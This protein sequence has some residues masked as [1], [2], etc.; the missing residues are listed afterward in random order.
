VW[1]EVDLPIVARAV[2]AFT[3]SVGEFGAASLIARPERPA[4]PVAVWF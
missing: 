4:M 3:V 2:F 1:R